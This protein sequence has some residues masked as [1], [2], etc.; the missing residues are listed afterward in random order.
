MHEYKGDPVMLHFLHPYFFLLQYLVLNPFLS[1]HKDN[2]LS[3]TIR[4]GDCPVLVTLLYTVCIVDT[5]NKEIHCY[6]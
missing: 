4:Y 3:T 1:Q 5:N 6:S 2:L